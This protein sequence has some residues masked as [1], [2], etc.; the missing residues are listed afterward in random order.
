MLDVENL[1]QDKA[2]WPFPRQEAGQG[3]SVYVGGEQGERD[4]V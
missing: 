2:E 4:D 1:D 3:K